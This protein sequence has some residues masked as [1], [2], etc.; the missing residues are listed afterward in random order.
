MFLMLLPVCYIVFQD[1]TVFIEDSDTVSTDLF[2]DK[3]TL[4]T[5]DAS[6]FKCR[7][8]TYGELMRLSSAGKLLS[9][10][11]RVF[12]IEF[13]WLAKLSTKFEKLPAG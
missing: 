8:I 4:L 2:R 11:I 7:K 6:L 12:Q 10:S 9:F 5:C 13:D 3:Y 1:A